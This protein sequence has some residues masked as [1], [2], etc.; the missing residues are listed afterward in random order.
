MGR[1]G[2]E[3]KRKEKK[4]QRTEENFILR[5]KE[6]AGCSCAFVLVFSFLQRS[7]S[8]HACALFLVNGRS[9]V[10][11]VMDVSFY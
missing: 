2:Q 1:C 5:A 10:V 6:H 3:R 11:V 8:L 4:K 9:G 7:A